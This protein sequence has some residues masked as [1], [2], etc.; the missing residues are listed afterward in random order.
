VDR[1][2]R[3]AILAAPALLACLTGCSGQGNPENGAARGAA[4]RFETSTSDG[5]VA[6]VL[7]APRSRAALEES[8]GSTCTAA[9]PALRLEPGGRVTG[10]QV[11]GKDAQVR[12]E[13][14]TVFLARFDDGWRVTAA[15]CTPAGDLPYDCRIS[16]G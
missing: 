9:L 2:G 5:A 15:G 12:L 7:L 4:V 11:Y 14:D 16:G 8:S 1:T 3:V 13:Q 10:V 6:C